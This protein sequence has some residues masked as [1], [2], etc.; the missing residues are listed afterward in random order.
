MRTI[1]TTPTT[2]T[3]PT[4]PTIPTIPAG[5]AARCRL[6]ALT[7]SPAA[8]GV[9]LA[10]ALATLAPRPAAADD[11]GVWKAFK[12]KVIVSD[13]PFEASADSDKAM[14]AGI[15]KQ[16]RAVITGADGQWTLNMMAFLK[17]PAGAASVNVVY[18]D[19]TDPKN[20]EQ[21]NFAEVSVQPSQKTIQLNGTS[22]SK[23]LGFVA[24]HRYEV[25]VTRLV[26]GKEDVYAKATITLK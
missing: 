6:R 26:G 2:P 9:V 1:P 10:I 16:A 23:E 17:A 20:R 12:G 22:I 21:V 19:V 7:A 25:L 18:Y 24:G 4:I 14:I 15:K 11:T 8:T 13:A 5:P 3:T